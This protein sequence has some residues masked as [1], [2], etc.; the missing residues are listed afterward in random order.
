MGAG[1]AQVSLDKGYNVTLKD[2]ANSGL[3]RGVTQIYNGM[4]KKAKRKKITTLVI[5]LLF[6]VEWLI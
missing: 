2:M 6:Y 3:S 1:I 5:M 4:D